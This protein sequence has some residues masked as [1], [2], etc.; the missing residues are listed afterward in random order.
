VADQGNSEI[1]K[2]VIS[3]GVVSTLAGTNV[4]GTGVMGYVD[5][6]GSA[7]RFNNPVGITSDGVS[8][9]V[10]DMYNYNIRKIQ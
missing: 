5:G 6:V 7:A 9:Y 4:S 10:S 8:L 1:R 3:T 2:I